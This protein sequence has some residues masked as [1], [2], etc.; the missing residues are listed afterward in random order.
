[1]AQTRRL[2]RS[3]R[4]ISL[5]KIWFDN[6]NSSVTPLD[7]TINKPRMR[8]SKTLLWWATHSIMLRQAIMVSF[9]AI[10]IT[11]IWKMNSYHRDRSLMVDRTTVWVDWTI[12]LTAAVNASTTSWPSINSLTRLI[13]LTTCYRWYNTNSIRTSKYSCSKLIMWWLN[14]VMPAAIMWTDISSKLAIKMAIWPSKMMHRKRRKAEYFMKRWFRASRK[15]LLTNNFRTESSN[16]GGRLRRSR[17]DGW[18]PLVYLRTQQT[19]QCKIMSR[20]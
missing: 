1:M 17:W 10:R 19:I 15:R 13:G 3:I 4:S 8:S 11:C 6:S 5:T 7:S 14:R 9:L 12:I 2:T 18:H 20:K 16:W